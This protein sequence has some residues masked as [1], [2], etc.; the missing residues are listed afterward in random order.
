MEYRA[1]VCAVTVASVPIGS[2]AGLVWGE[3]LPGDL[4][5][6]TKDDHHESAHKVGCIGLFVEHITRVVE[7]FHVLVS[8]ISKHAAELPDVFVRVSQVQW[9]KV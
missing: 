3:G 4:G 6:L 5:L 1:A 8:L 9:T 7:Q 2:E